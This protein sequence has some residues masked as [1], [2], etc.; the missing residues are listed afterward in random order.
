MPVRTR[1]LTKLTKELEI[2]KTDNDQVNFKI[3]KLEFDKILADGQ[4][5]RAEYVKYK[6]ITHL[7]IKLQN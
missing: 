3:K 1:F 2:L 6:K 4:K 5:Q 7:R